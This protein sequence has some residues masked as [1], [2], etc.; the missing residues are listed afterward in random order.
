MAVSFWW[1][2]TAICLVWY[3]TVTVYVTIRG[4]FDIKRMLARLDEL[5]TDDEQN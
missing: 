3:S 2:L 4:G 5:R 1:W